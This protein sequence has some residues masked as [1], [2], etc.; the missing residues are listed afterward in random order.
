MVGQEKQ[1]LS[2][3]AESEKSRVQQT[4]QVATTA[5]NLDLVSALSF[6]GEGPWHAHSVMQATLCNARF[7]I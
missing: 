1:G 7:I 4:K 3:C 6:D 2:Y 5:P